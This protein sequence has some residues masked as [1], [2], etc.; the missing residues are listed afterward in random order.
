MMN[1]MMTILAVAGVERGL[2]S[3]MFIMIDNS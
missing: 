2:L 1:V 3:E